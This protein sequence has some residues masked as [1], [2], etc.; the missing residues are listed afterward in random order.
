[1]GVLGDPHPLLRYLAF[2]ARFRVLRHPLD[3]FD[4]EHP[5]PQT[6]PEPVA[7]PGLEQTSAHLPGDRVPSWPRRREQPVSYQRRCFQ[8]HLEHPPPGPQNDLL[9]P[10]RLTHPPH[11]PLRL[12]DP[13][14]PL[15]RSAPR[16]EK[17]TPPWKLPM[18]NPPNQ[19]SALLQPLIPER[20]SHPRQPPGEDRRF[21]R[22]GAYEP[23]RV[24]VACGS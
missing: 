14:H 9:F 18:E 12:L 23:P 17:S 13:R 3:R 1:M 7:P 22:A 20:L 6:R 16:S 24:F 19:L 11:P 4:P 21:P 5:R 10:R 8:L 2:L 15:H